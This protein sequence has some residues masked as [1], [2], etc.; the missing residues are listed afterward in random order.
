MNKYLITVFTTDEKANE[1]STAI[2]P[3]LKVSY[4]CINVTN[5]TWEPNSVTSK[6]LARYLVTADSQEE[7]IAEALLAQDCETD[8][9]EVLA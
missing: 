8:R 4:S 1:N 3:V 9:V 2:F 5:V 7:A 6:N